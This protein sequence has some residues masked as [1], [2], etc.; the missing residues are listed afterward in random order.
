MF[1]RENQPAPPSPATP[2]QRQ[3]VGPESRHADVSPLWRQLATGACGGC[4][5]VLAALARLRAA[6]AAFGGPGPAQWPAALDPAA[7]FEYLLDEKFASRHAAGAPG[8]AANAALAR[9]CAEAVEQRFTQALGPQG[10]APAGQGQ[11]VAAA[12]DDLAAAGAKLFDALDQD[13]LLS[14]ELRKRRAPGHPPKPS[15]PAE[16]DRGAP[17]QAGG[18]PD[19]ATH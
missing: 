4:A 3:R 13:A 19:R 12:V 6:H 8:P 14:D 15:P 1:D 16:A 2:P 18:Q 11:E 7:L 10:R 17:G 9:R 5:D